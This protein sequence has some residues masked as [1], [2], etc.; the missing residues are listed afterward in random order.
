VFNSVFRTDISQ[1]TPHVTPS[2]RFADAGQS[3]GTSPK[4][5]HQPTGSAQSSSFVAA[6]L[7]VGQNQH[8]GRPRSQQADSDDIGL[9]LYQQ[10]GTQNS[11]LPLEGS[12]YLTPSS[13][14]VPSHMGNESTFVAS[15]PLIQVAPRSPDHRRQQPGPSSVAAS[16]A[17]AAADQIRFD[18]AWHVVTSAIALPCSATADD[19][20]G[21]LTPES[22]YAQLVRRSGSS[23]S[24]LMAALEVVLHP[25]R[26]V[27]RA[28]HTENVVEW[29]MQQVRRHFAVHVQPLLAACAEPAELERV[30]ARDDGTDNEGASGDGEMELDEEEADQD[31]EQQPQSRS[32]RTGRGVFY[33]RNLLIVMSGIRTLESALQ[34]YLHGATLIVRGIEQAPDALP[35]QAGE[36]ALDQ[37]QK[38]TLALFSNSAPAELLGALRVVLIR[39][40][41]FILG[42]PAPSARDGT[43][44]YGIGM[45]R[46]TIPDQDNA[47]AESARAKLSELLESLSHVGLAGERFEVLFAEVMDG[48]M[49]S[50]IKDTYAGVWSTPKNAQ[51]RDKYL[52]SDY[53]AP[54]STPSQIS[55]LSSPSW[56]TVSLCDW[57]ENHFA[58]LAHDVLSS[59]RQ[60]R[61]GLKHASQQSARPVVALA[62]VK[63][64]QETAMDRLAA[65]RISELFDIVLAWPTS[66][67]GLDDLRMAVT[68]PQTRMQL[69]TSFS[70]TVQRRLLHPGRSTLEILQTYIAMIRTFHV[71]DNSKVLLG[72]VA[73]QLQLYLCQREDAVRIVVTG[74]LANEE[75]IRAAQRSSSNSSNDKLVELAKL[76]NDPTQ[77]RKHAF[78][79]PEL[80]WGDMDWVPDPIDAGANYRR[81]RSEDVIGTLVDA[82]GSPEVFI[83]EFQ[84]ILAERLL[85]SQIGFGQ[86][87]RVLELLKRR[88]GDAALQS[89]EVM[90]RDV[91]DSK[92]LDDSIHK[93]KREQRHQQGQQDKPKMVEPEYHARILS[94]LFWPDLGR[95]GMVIPAEVSA[96]QR[97][98]DQQYQ[99]L[100]SSRKLT[101]LDHL[102]QATVELELQD[103]T[104]A[105]ECKTYEATV[106]YAFQ[107]A[108]NTSSGSVR[109]T[110]EQL[111]AK[112]QIDEDLL[113]AAL[114]LWVSKGVLRRDRHGFYTVIETVDDDTQT[115]APDD[116]TDDSGPPPGASSTG[117]PA[118]SSAAPDKEDPRKAVY[119]QFVKGMLTNTSAQM[120]L[121]QIAMMLKVLIDGFAWSNE[122]LQDFL[123]ERVGD[124]DL[125][126]VGGKFKLL[127]KPS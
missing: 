123:M 15:T 63:Q 43:H 54:L 97:E 80:D 32:R 55:A 21:T 67:R 19:S 50:F 46:P 35:G 2:A 1:P 53:E 92:K 85:S 90:M 75:E 31:Q 38:D 69:T 62:D 48:L 34:L 20:F 95:D 64:W 25:A 112:L 60:G 45:P 68:T 12:N 88:F 7:Q 111:E 40:V 103:R 82:L 71:L 100:K 117:S 47:E 5:V 58:R 78:E 89:C 76:L 27:P 107:Q 29:H 86:E 57:V 105:V 13:G 11:L 77:Q 81:P 99:R 26:S 125:E 115:T 52:N 73:P 101:W 51:N 108:D 9:G 18:H 102:G 98:Y 79:D 93:L 23:E 104:I 8:Y 39:L 14:L 121:A 109:Y 96:Q 126:V 91:K 72:R 33:D 36:E 3:F 30:A 106:I 42:F 66:R 56:C 114:Q 17:V 10:G 4:H 41:G 127:R 22:Q 113:Q 118:K 49:T 87:L 74:L 122:E 83:K 44:N 120:P 94:R 119:W 37:L 61:A 110:V 24:G 6:A 116:G 124:G 84:A 28:M 70:A 65:L 16:A 59:I